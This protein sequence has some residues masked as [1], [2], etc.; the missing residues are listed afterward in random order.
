MTHQEELDLIFR[1]TQGDTALFEHL[2]TEHQKTVYNL[3]LRMLGRPE[4]AQDAS[5]EAFMR[6]YTGLGDFRGEGRFGAWLYRLTA[7]VCLDQLRRRK[8]RGEVPLTRQ[9]ETGEEELPLPDE[10]FCPETEAERQELREAVRRAMRRLPPEAAQ[11]LS[12]REIGGLSYEEIASQ[13]QL[14]SGTVK[15]RLS[16]ARKKLLL[17]LSADRNFSP[18]EASIGKEGETHDL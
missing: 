3:A 18:P 10:R 2:V 13:L 12:L 1:I 6:A 11:I 5:Q 15:S 16:R 7:N 14:E 8:R 17:I 4:D 9:T